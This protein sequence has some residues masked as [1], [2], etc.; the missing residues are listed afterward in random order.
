MNLP[1][2]EGG[3][4]NDR[5]GTKNKPPNKSGNDQRGRQKTKGGGDR[6]ITGTKG[7][8]KDHSLVTSFLQFL[9]GLLVKNIWELTEKFLVKN[10]RRLLRM[11]VIVVAT[12]HTRPKTVG[13]TQIVP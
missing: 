13:Y 7:V 4:R 6:E 2:K 10:L 5:V 8:D 12:H 3:A 11:L 9:R 1:T